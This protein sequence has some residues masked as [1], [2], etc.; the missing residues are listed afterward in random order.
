MIKR[1]E[2]SYHGIFQKSLGKYI[3]SDCSIRSRG[4]YCRRSQSIRASVALDERLIL[5]LHL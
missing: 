3:G 2:V 1:V 4:S 5:S